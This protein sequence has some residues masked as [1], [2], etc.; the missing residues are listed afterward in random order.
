[1]N[2]LRSLYPAGLKYSHIIGTGG[3]GSGIFFSLRDNHTLGRN[4][5]RMATLE[6]YND[7]CKQ[8]II[9]HYIAVLL[10]GKS[11]NNFK[12]FPIGK[13]G[14]DET[15]KRLLRQMQEAG[16]DTGNIEI[17][18]ESSTLFSVCFQYPDHS[19]GNITTDNGASAQV[20]PEVISH[21]FENYHL[22]GE[23]GIILA[24]PEVPV[25]SRVELLKFGKN[26]RS[27]NV[28]SL[29]SSEVSEFAKLGGFHLTDILAINIDEARNIAQIEDDSI[30]ATEIISSCIE[31]LVKV[32]SSLTVIITEGVRGSYCYKD[33]NLES[34][35]A[36]ETRA[37]STA[38]AGDAFLAG[39]ISGICCGLSVHKGYSSKV[40]SEFPIQTAVELGTLLASL[41]VTSPNTIN[42]DIDAKLLIE[43]AQEKKVSM[44]PDFIKI[45]SACID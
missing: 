41:S 12:L 6:P 7:F 25:E 14:N 1:M 39:T 18:Q 11:M 42:N 15:G 26:N 30:S 9:M 19:G 27:L 32:N 24:V 34:T 33:N 17:C 10:S 20:T 37:I 21:F 44:G 2:I 3:V 4:E 22:E 40:F 13:V 16:M 23:K 31:K 29:L 8:H 43:Y 5:S 45:F 38:G 35:P 28:A 36:L